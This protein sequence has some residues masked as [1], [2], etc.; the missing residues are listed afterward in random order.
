MRKRIVISLLAGLL[1]V[2]GAKWLS[3]NFAMSLAVAR[4]AGGLAGAA[5]GYAAS[6]F[7]DVLTSQEE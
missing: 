3:E 2:L 7:F 4:V 5:I 6:Q 1:G